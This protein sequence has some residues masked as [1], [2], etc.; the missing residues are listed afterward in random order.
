MT[1]IGIRAEVFVLWQKARLVALPLLLAQLE[2]S[3]L[4]SLFLHLTI[5]SF[6]IGN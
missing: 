3:A 2:T 1:A 6:F 5:L 4:A